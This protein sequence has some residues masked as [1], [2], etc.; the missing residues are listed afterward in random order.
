MQ[1]LEEWADELK[2]SGKLVLVEGS[3]DANALKRLGIT[4]IMTV[5]QKANF[6]VV[7]SIT[8]HE[9]VILTDIDQEGRKYY[10]NLKHHLQRKGVK[11]DKRFREFLIKNTKVSY[12]ESIKI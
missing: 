6:Q 5:S 7:E 8:D 12:I 9:V 3:K 4:K 1:S 2:N 11:I 10:H